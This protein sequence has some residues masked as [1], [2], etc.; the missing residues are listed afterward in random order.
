MFSKEATNDRCHALFRVCD[1][2]VLSD[3]HAP[4]NVTEVK[5]VPEVTAVHVVCDLIY[6]FSN[7]HKLDVMTFN[8]ILVNYFIPSLHLINYTAIPSRGDRHRQSSL[9]MSCGS[10]WEAPE[11]PH[12]PPL[13]TCIR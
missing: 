4:C 13:E 12:S 11:A 8:I 9:A 2:E 3:A 6:L 10:A 7:L 5:L 1:V